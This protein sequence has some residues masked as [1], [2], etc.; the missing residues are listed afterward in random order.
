MTARKIELRHIKA[1][2]DQV[3]TPSVVEFSAEKEELSRKGPLSNPSQDGHRSVSF[4][5]SSICEGKL[6]KL[7]YARDSQFTL[8]CQREEVSLS[9]R[10]PFTPLSRTQSLET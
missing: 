1:I 8:L 2:V 3:V 9:N 7:D 10:S 5:I 4:K 6:L